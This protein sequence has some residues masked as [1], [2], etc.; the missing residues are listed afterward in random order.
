[1]LWTPYI[2]RKSIFK[3]FYIYINHYYIILLITIKYITKTIEH[4]EKYLL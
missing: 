1:M 4:L 2:V 3:L